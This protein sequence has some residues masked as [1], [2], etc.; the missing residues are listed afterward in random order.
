MGIL[1]TFIKG[2]IAGVVGLGALSWLY[3]AV[4]AEKD[5]NEDE[6]EDE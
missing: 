4:I 3:T 5:E 2:A 1:G 6:K